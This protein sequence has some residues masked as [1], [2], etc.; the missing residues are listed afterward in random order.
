MSCSLK[1]KLS[2]AS[3]DLVARRYYPLHM[4]PKK[5]AP[6]VHRGFFKSTAGIQPNRQV[7]TLPRNEVPI[8]IFK[9]TKERF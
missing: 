8:P 5:K 7:A 2:S 1:V 4:P 9:E 6:V 3:P